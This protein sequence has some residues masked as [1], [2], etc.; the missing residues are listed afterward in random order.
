MSAAARRGPAAGLL[1]TELAQG[2]GEIGHQIGERALE[3]LAPRDDDV[4]VAAKR[5]ALQ[6]LACGGAQAAARPVSLDGVADL[7]GNGETDPGIVVGFLVSGGFMSWL[8]GGLKDEAGFDA[9]MGCRRHP[10]E[11]RAR[12]QAPEAHGHTG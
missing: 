7:P 3:G 4:V 6:N 1:R 2:A 10:Q 11:V 12:L 8:K 5:V 9:F